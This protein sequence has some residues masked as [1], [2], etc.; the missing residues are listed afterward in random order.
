MHKNAKSE[1]QSYLSALG[2]R[3]L[4]FDGAMGTNIQLH[5]PTP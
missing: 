2:E 4:V 5:H 3:V 1:R